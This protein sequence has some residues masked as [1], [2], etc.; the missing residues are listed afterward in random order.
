MKPEQRISISLSNIVLIISSFLLLILLWQVRSLI[1]L[2]MVAVV[3]AASI[4]PLVNIAEKMK[5]P[6]WLGVII[7][8]LTLISGLIS[9]ALTIGP[10]VFDQIETLLRQLPLFSESIGENIEDFISSLIQSPP[11][12][13]NQLFDTKSVTSWVIRSSQQLLLRSYSLT[14]GVLGGVVSLILALFISGYM[15]ADSKT[16]INGLVKLFPQ[17]WDKRLENQVVPVTQ[18]MG[19]YIRGRIIVSAILGIATTTGLGFLGLKDFSLGL[20]AIASVTNLIP[21]IG[22]I[23]GAIPALI[24]AIAKGGWLFLWVIILYYIIQNVETYVL[25]PLLV[26]SSVGVHPLYQLLS[27]LVGIQLLGIIGALIVPPWFAGG[28]ALVE[29]LYLK[30]KLEAENMQPLVTNNG[31]HNSPPVTS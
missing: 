2:L 9:V 21:F 23:L 22:P 25:D 14:K 4:S 27:V 20:G 17:P 31:D 13:I 29:N 1:V 19:G 5:L 10:P 15:L 8:Y 16:L 11:D 7:V 12:W 6:R 30:P 26:G 3:L 24:V 28:A 18:R